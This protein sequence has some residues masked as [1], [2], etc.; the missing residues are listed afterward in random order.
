MKRMNVNFYV[1]IVPM[2]LD[3]IIPEPKW[4]HVDYFLSKDVGFYVNSK[5][6]DILR[7]SDWSDL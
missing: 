7:S 3:Y 5:V 4:S 2:L 1:I 6:I